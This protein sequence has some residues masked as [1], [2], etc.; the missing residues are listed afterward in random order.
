MRA[1]LQYRRDCNRADSLSTG[2]NATRTVQES[3]A[4]TLLGLL[5]LG[6]NWLLPAKLHSIIN[7]ERSAC[8]AGATYEERAKFIGAVA[9]SRHLTRTLAAR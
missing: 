5:N 6:Q 1:L 3:A 9:S 8:I 7:A 4:M 2:T